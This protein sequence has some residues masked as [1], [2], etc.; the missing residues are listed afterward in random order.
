MDAGSARAAESLPEPLHPPQCLCLELLLISVR[1]GELTPSALTPR[2]AP[3]PLVREKQQGKE[4]VSGRQEAEPCRV[5]RSTCSGF[6]KQG[7]VNLTASA[8][9]QNPKK[10][11]QG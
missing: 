10:W 7:K 2:A 11:E 3:N 1:G 9:L 5:H 8:P 6:N 4:S